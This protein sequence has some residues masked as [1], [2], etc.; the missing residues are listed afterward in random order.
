MLE[1]FT[2]PFMQRAIVAGILVGALA[3]Y[4]GVF[5]VQRGLSFL[6]SGLAHAA[7]G[8]VA[9][10]ILLNQEP[11]WVA[12]PF[13]IAV[14]AGIN[15]V[16]RRGA[17]AGDTAIGVFFAVSMA[18][19]II[20]LSFTDRFATDAASYLFGSILYVTWT[21]VAVTGV[22]AA[23][24][25]ATIGAWGRWAYATLDREL[26]RADRVPV[27]RDDYLL[28]ISLAVMIVVAMK[29]VGI[30][31]V[32]AF[33]VIPAASARLASR[34]FSTMTLLSI[35][36]GATSALAGLVLSYAIEIPSGPTIV[37]L[38]AAVF[39]CLLAAKGRG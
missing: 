38:Q 31:L 26:A 30:V 11:L 10:G 2:M 15:W 16:Q 37:L 34:R 33:A 25:L 19:G 32:A 7:F 20:F 13:T 27:A 22:V 39:F 1:L 21:D 4:Y 14:A 23:M 24:A 3:S 28:S 9:L 29:V 6:G 35:A 8:G 12:I 17:V 36:I 18:L 5:I